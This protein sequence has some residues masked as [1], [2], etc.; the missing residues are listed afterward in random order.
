MIKLINGYID[1]SF[2]LSII[3]FHIPSRNLRMFAPIKMNNF[4]NNNQ[5][6][7]MCTHFNDLS[8][9]VDY[10]SSYFVVKKEIINYLN[11][12]TKVFY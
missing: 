10:S 9:K 5:F 1:S 7:L 3:N 8:S 6:L 12:T 11:L 2:L 4:L